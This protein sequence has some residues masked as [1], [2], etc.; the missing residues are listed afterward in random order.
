MTGIDVHDDVGKVETPESICDTFTVTR[1]R[2]DAGLQLDVGDEVGQGIGLD[3]EGD[4][5]VGVLLEDGNDGCYESVPRF[6]EWKDGIG[7]LR[8]MYSDL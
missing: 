1:R 4:G 5:G 6:F 7:S 2:V 3:D 8:S